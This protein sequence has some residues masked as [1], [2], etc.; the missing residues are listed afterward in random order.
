[1]PTSFNEVRMHGQFRGE[2]SGVF[3]NK[4]IPVN[5]DSAASFVAYTENLFEMIGGKHCDFCSIS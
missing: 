5:I 4:M 1:M 3:R 2:N